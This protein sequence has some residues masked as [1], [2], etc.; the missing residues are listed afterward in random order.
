MLAN[1]EGSVLNHRNVCCGMGNFEEIGMEA[2]VP[3]Q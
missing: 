1:I 2:Y 3:Q